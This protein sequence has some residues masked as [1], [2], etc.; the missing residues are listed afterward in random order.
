MLFLLHLFLVLNVSHR[1]TVLFSCEILSLITFLCEKNVCQCYTLC[2]RDTYPYKFG[3][4]IMRRWL[5]QSI[6]L[7]RLNNPTSVNYISTHMSL[8]SSLILRVHYK[9]FV[10]KS[11]FAYNAYNTIN[12]NLLVT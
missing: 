12:Y 4:L 1:Y 7:R 10:S 6:F 11:N 5:L 8:K 9:H 2:C 3:Q